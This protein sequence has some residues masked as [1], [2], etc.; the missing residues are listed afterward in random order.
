MIM[1]IFIHRKIK[2]E[3]GFTLVEVMIALG[4]LSF[5]VLA[6][7]S[8]QSSALLGTS[9]SNS[10]TVATN[11]ATDRMERLMAIPYDN[12]AVLGSGNN[13]YFTGAPALPLNM[14][15]QDI[16]WNVT[17][18]SVASTLRITVSVQPRDM[19]NKITLTNLKINAF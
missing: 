9:R 7:A 8:M 6:V 3:R 2:S 5:G 4:I 10:V 17:P 11:I 14:K 16:T 13:T 12:L 1:G 19:R 15:N 18:G